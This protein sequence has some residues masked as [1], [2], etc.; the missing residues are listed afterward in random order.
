TLSASPG[1]F[2]GT[3]L[4]L[5]FGSG[6]TA[7]FGAL[8]A[9]LFPTE[10]RSVAMGTTYNLAR[11]TQ[12]L[13]PVLVGAMVSSYGLKGGLS[14]PLVLALATASW[15]WALPE[16]RGIALPTLASTPAPIAEK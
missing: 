4:L 8:L 2:W 13:S 9:E 14:V 7:G 3:M 5:G 15:V 16:T 12:L 1:L 11:A 10:V 6:C